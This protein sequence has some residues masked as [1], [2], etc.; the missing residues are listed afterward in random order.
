M[1][2]AVP[3]KYKS[4]NHSA[5]ASNREEMRH[6][7]CCLSHYRAPFHLLHQLKYFSKELQYFSQIEVEVKISSEV[8]LK[9]ERQ[10]KWV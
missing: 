9:E 3:I 6:G 7:I 8:I 1:V 2:K 10:Q 4:V 5:V